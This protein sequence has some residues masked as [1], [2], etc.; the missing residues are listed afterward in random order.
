MLTM[1]SGQISQLLGKH[2]KSFLFDI[3]A[4]LYYSGAGGASQSWFV[5]E[6]RN[7]GIIFDQIYSWELTVHHPQKIFEDLP[8]EVLVA[9]HYYNIG[10]NADHN[11][12][13]NP[14]RFIRKLSRR[15][16]FVVVKLDIDN[17]A[18]EERLVHDLL[19][20]S[21]ALGLIDEFYWEHH[22]GGNPMQYRGWGRQSSNN[23]VQSYEL[24]G[25]LRGHG[26]RAHS[27]V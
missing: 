23:I 4:S 14:W 5:E 27:W 13:Y 24:F 17:V 6:Y 3:G 22:T 11:S 15:S 8:F 20:D 26:I 12:K 19:N 25:R 1:S 18:M 16:D 10:V 21:I 7:V 9:M 2:A